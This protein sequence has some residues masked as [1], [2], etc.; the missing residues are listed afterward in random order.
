MSRILA[1]LS[2]LAPSAR[3]WRGAAWGLII[4]GGVFVAVLARDELAP[5]ER[6]V[7]A[8]LTLL[9]QLA[10]AV[11]GGGLL[12]LLVALL[13]STPRF[14][15][16][17]LFG[18]ALLLGPPLYYIGT[19]KLGI[20]V[21]VVAVA[22]SASLTGAAVSVLTAGRELGAG[23]KRRATFA[24]LLT[25]VTMVSLGF[26]WLLRDGFARES[27]KDAAIEAPR[28]E[29]IDLPNPASPG[30]FAV[31]KLNYGSG[32]DRHRR[33]YGPATDLETKA[34]DG[35]PFIE[36][37]TGLQGWARTRYWGFDATELPLQG[38]VFYPEGTGP[39]PLVLIVHGNHRAED[40][41]DRGYDYLGELLAS[42][43]YIVVSVD[44]NFLNGSAVDLFGFPDLG[45]KEETDARAWL[46]LE[47]LRLWRD[48]NGAAGNPFAGKVDLERIALIGHSRGG[49]AVTVAAVFN[50]L[51]VYPDDARVPFGYGFHLGAVIAIAPVD[52]QYKPAGTWAKIENVDYFVLHGSHDADMKSFHGSRVF[53]R[54]RFTDAAEHFKAGLYIHRANHGQFNTSWGRGD[55]D[56]FGNLLL[57]LRPIMSAE[58]QTRI[59][60]VYISAFLEASLKGVSG[61][62]ALF[63]D[64]RSAPGWLP[65]GIFLSQYD[66]NATRYVCRY[67]EDIDV[68]TT[69]APGG[70]IRG[71]NLADWRES[72]I[73]LKWGSL[74]TRAVSI[75]WDDARSPLADYS[76]TLPDI[77]LTI[78][79]ASTLTFQLA[80]PAQDPKKPLG[81]KSEPVPKS[82][83]E[84][85]REKKDREPIDFSIEV[86]D[87]AGQVARLPL[88]RRA[89]LQPQIDFQVAKASVFN[90]HPSSEIV[91]QVFDLPLAVFLEQNPRLDPTRLRAIRFVFDRTRRGVI[92][93]DDV[94][95]RP[96]P[97]AA[98]VR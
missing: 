37:W 42:R 46:L 91:F 61:Y 49:E 21:I 51:P 64:H 16:W 76:I 2:S 12:L 82:L 62:R 70:A 80:D 65:G 68:T 59:A 17:T 45:L 14:Y 81:A 95:F 83:D 3:A 36:R 98:A 87:S 60:K 35:S 7:V 92:V 53:E 97:S 25:G 20:L 73:K 9:V 55:A 69:T 31:R 84:G 57:N 56:G 30:P 78:D 67:E 43:G 89:A 15:R 71:T 23:T 8:L 48:W 34:V 32:R 79:G 86:A 88:S 19:A 18:L 27:P 63:R 40:F 38:R 74:D 44:E 39:F 11:V 33:E 41:S 28:P 13:S 24:A 58:D 6:N 66:D 90:E 96:G 29:P 1:W 52:G 10:V 26:F 47:H 4:A 85:A 72:E 93:L 22:L 5:R 50:R 54:V 94:G 75:G 77:G